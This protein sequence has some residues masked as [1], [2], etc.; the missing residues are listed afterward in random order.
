MKIIDQKS[1]NRSFTS[2]ELAD[3]QSTLQ[4]VQCDSCEKWRL[5]IGVENDEEL[6]D[7]WYCRMNITD[8]R[9]NSCDAPERNQRWY[10]QNCLDQEAQCGD[11]SKLER[12]LTEKDEELE[13]KDEILRHL[14]RVTMKGK[15]KP[16][17][18]RHYFHDS[19]LRST[20]TENVD[21]LVVSPPEK[22]TYQ[23]TGVSNTL[24]ARIDEQDVGL[25]GTSTIE[26]A[27]TVKQENEGLPPIDISDVR[28]RSQ[29]EA[30]SGTPGR[31]AKR[32][33]DP[34]SSSSGRSPKKLK[35]LALSQSTVSEKGRAEVIDLCDSD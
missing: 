34:A 23:D 26:T 25:A 2:K 13:Q 32:Q 31:R 16:L 24:E 3:L 19:L 8:P 28:G 21:Q 20:N 29:A 9:H 11:E 4:W 14:L 27:S 22:A 1:I 6:P 18:S 7:K 35:Q 5:Q 10:E 17:I 30:K 33:K 12:N 15:Q